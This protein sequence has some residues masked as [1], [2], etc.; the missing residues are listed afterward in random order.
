MKEF[1]FTVALLVAL[2]GAV[3]AQDLTSI[4]FRLRDVDGKDFSFQEFLTDARD[5]KERGAV[6]ISFWAMWCEPCKQEMKALVPV[7]EKYREHNFH[8]LAVNLDNPRSL[9]K[10]KAYVRAQKLPYTF[11]LDPNSEI[12]KKLNGQ[13]M[14]YS[15]LIDQSGTLIAKRTGFNAGEEKE[16]E[17]DIRKILE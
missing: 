5:G 8:Y 4:D 15:L 10:V 17:E 2:S 13:G 9:A 16:I 12:F 14:P 6:L 7:F 11:L 1:L 3:V